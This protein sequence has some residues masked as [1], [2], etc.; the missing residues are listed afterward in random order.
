MLS[1]R[2]LM[3]GA[4]NIKR[5]IEQRFLHNYQENIVLCDAAQIRAVWSN[6][7]DTMGH[8]SNAIDADKGKRVGKRLLCAD[9]LY[10]QPHV[11]QHRTMLDARQNGSK[12]V[13]RELWSDLVVELFSNTT[14]KNLPLLFI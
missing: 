5:F 3:K 2:E 11:G 1:N 14:F 13:G 10:G 7:F 4:S 6:L 9:I 8:R 12:Y